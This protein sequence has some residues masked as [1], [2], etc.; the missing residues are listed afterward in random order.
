[1]YQRDEEHGYTEVAAVVEQ[2]QET[3]I[4]AAKRA[5]AENDREQQKRAG[6]GGSND[7][8]FGGGL[9]KEQSAE[10]NEKREIDQHTR[11]ENKIVSALL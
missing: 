4:Q 10:P 5:D 3:R 6:T 9:G 7:E 8:S 1:M 11:G 2:R